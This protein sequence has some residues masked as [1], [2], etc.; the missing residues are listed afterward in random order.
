MAH[1]RLLTG[2]LRL[3]D[4]L[5]ISITFDRLLILVILLIR[6]ATSTMSSST[7]GIPSSSSTPACRTCGTSVSSG[8]ICLRCCAPSPTSSPRR[9]APLVEPSR[10]INGGMSRRD[11]W[12]SRY[13][14]SIAGQ[15]DELEQ[16][17]AGPSGYASQDEEQYHPT[18]RPNQAKRNTWQ[19]SSSA[20]AAISSQGGS[21]RAPY[22]RSTTAFSMGIGMPS[23]ISR[24][25]RCS[26][27]SAGLATTPEQPSSS[28]SRIPLPD[29]QDRPPLS[30]ASQLLRSSPSQP[31]VP[32][33]PRGATGGPI[34][35]VCG[36]VLDPASSRNK[37]AC[38]DCTVVFARDSTIYVPPKTGGQS[39]PTEEEAFYCKDCYTRRFSLG[40]CANQACGKAVLGSTK[41][42]GKF[43]KTSLG[44]VYHGIC[45]RCHNCQAGGGSPPGGDGIEVMMDMGGRPSCPDCFG[46]TPR[47]REVVGQ[48]NGREIGSRPGVA[49]ATAMSPSVDDRQPFFSTVESKP[50]A[51]RG[52]TN[53]N[54]RLKGTIAELSQR[55]EGLSSTSK[56]NAPP[57]QARASEPPMMPAIQ[58]QSTSGNLSPIRQ[59]G[60]IRP[61][62]VR[63]K[64]NL[65]MSSSAS[66]N[67]VTSETPASA[68]RARSLS[69][70]KPSSDAST[71]SAT[72]SKPQTSTK[73]YLLPRNRQEAQ[74]KATRDSIQ[75]TSE[76]VP[77]PSSSPLAVE[78]IKCAACRLGPFD[79]RSYDR[80]DQHEVQMIT[81]PAASGNQTGGSIARPL[82]HLHASCFTCDVCRGLIGSNGGSSSFVR[83]D[84]ATDRDGNL[85]RFAHPA[86]APPVHET[87]REAVYRSDN[88]NTA[89]QT[90]TTSSSPL[91]IV[92]S[93]PTL[94]CFPRVSVEPEEADVDRGRRRRLPSPP[95]PTVISTAYL[96]RP[97]QSSATSPSS[98]SQKSS[99]CP[100][101][102]PLRYGSS[103]AMTTT[104]VVQTG[105]PMSSSPSKNPAAGMFSSVGPSS[106]SS[107]PTRRRFPSPTR[108]G[109]QQ[110]LSDLIPSTSTF[111]PSRQASPLQSFEAATAPSSPKRRQ[112]GGMDQCSGCGRSLTSFE[113]VPGP[114]GSTWH[115]KCLVCK[116][117]V[118]DHQ[119]GKI[120]VCGKLLDSS[121]NVRQ[122]DQVVR[123]GSCF[124]AGR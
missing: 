118:I 61:I 13:L 2:V 78:E 33:N 65:A 99:Y 91:R 7:F 75:P 22:G 62:A 112:Y 50:L 121:A 67:R 101:V 103:A 8:P 97:V 117:Q 28:S 81:I 10:M 115:R 76:A 107:S 113:S 63:A 6:M 109:T 31:L 84:E 17:S 83:L 19:P 41:E 74:T 64:S 23:S 104:R 58:A 12:S 105:S 79:S 40:D 90:A 54:V 3:L 43:V 80:V 96:S 46:A 49:A 120:G 47:R 60:L 29:H 32:T 77:G 72:D 66:K 35:K 55:F 44:Q 11:P 20:A 24:D 4:L 42:M 124:R 30:R 53:A 73:G 27:S 37:W 93:H 82:M 15:D 9:R 87:F 71:A 36:S 38:W 1:A 5:F 57:V 94:R 52:Q 88:L 119:R 95:K 123:C 100:S 59:D 85:P 114:A 89:A 48:Q 110:V 92:S 56:R 14:S 70:F 98:G 34:S 25:L 122:E 16:K 116:G 39:S 45:F 69:P 26:P 106:T 18:Q 86:C 111:T 68:I 102:S 21:Y 51:S 108:S